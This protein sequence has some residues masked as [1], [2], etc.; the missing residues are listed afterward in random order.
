MQSV[1]R[2]RDLVVDAP[3]RESLRVALQLLQ[4][5][6]H[7]PDLVGLV[8]DREVR[9]VAEALR[10]AAQDAAA[11]SVEGE[12]PEPLAGAA[13]QPLQALL[14]LARRLVREGDRENL[15]RLRT[16]GVDQVRDA[17]G[18]DAGLPGARAGDDEQRPFG[19]E[20]GLP[21]RGIEVGEVLLRRGDGHGSM[22]ARPLWAA[23]PASLGPCRLEPR[24]GLSPTGPAGTLAKPARRDMEIVSK[25]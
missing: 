24:R 6:L 2:L 17:I 21:L 23:G 22:L 16:D 1:L 20:H 14:H 13:E 3:R 11:R 25:V 4:A 18:E 7:Q 5:L 19:G 9:A 15:V 12:D 8:V 10:L